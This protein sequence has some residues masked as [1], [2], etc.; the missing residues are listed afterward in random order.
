MV[1]QTGRCG[2]NCDTEEIGI[3]GVTGANVCTGDGCLSTPD[4]TET[5][6]PFE[7]FNEYLE[8]FAA[9]DNRLEHREQVIVEELLFLSRFCGFIGSRFDVDVHCESATIVSHFFMPE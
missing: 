5:N 3:S 8:P 6:P 9:N 1:S 2:N 4:P 7:R